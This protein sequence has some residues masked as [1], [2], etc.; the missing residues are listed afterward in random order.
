VRTTIPWLPTV[1]VFL[2]GAIF[3]LGVGS[4]LSGRSGGAPNGRLAVGLLLFATGTLLSTP[5]PVWASPGQ[6]RLFVLGLAALL[7]LTAVVLMISSYKPGGEP[8]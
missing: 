2:A 3:G 5:G 6:V 8:R 7:T 1:S 4:Y